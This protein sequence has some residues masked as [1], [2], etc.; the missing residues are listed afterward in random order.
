MSASIAPRDLIGIAA[1]TNHRVI[2]CGGRLP[3][4]LPEDFKHFKATTM[5]G[6]LVMGRVSY[7]EIGRPLPGREI[8]VMSRTAGDIPGVTVVRDWAQLWPLFPDKK[9]FLAGG[10]NVYAQGLHLCS[11]LILT[12]VRGDYAGDAYFPRWEDFFDAGTVMS[13]SPEFSI[14]RHRRLP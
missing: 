9:L 7:E 12:H 8:V 4:R 11:E 14:R 5:G 6:V 13:E 3:W 2:G 1:L 10:A